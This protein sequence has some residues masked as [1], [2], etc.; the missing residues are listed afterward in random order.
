M[1]Q[2]FGNVETTPGP[3]SSRKISGTVNPLSTPN[4][5]LQHSYN[6]MVMQVNH[7]REETVRHYTKLLD[8][9]RHRRKQMDDSIVKVNHEARVELD[10]ERVKQRAI[11]DHIA[12]GW[13]LQDEQKK[14]H[15]SNL[16]EVCVLSRKKDF[17]KALETTRANCV[18][19][20][21]DIQERITNVKYLTPSKREKHWLLNQPDGLLGWIPHFDDYKPICTDKAPNPSELAK[22]AE[23]CR[24]LTVSIFAYY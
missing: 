5:T 22:L 2:N 19:H 9:A 6:V 14:F 8:E 18:I 11:Q 13:N 4:K 3:A 1:A 15:E 24:I 17:L 23:I 16:R 10:A 21:I 12:N 20:E 7:S